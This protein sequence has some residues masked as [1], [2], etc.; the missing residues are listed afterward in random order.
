MNPKISFQNEDEST[1]FFSVCETIYWFSFYIFFFAM[2]FKWIL[3]LYESL[4]IKIIPI[5]NGTAIG[6]YKGDVVDNL[7]EQHFRTFRE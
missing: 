3:N 1:Y 6:E 2:Q 5:F 4:I 7:R